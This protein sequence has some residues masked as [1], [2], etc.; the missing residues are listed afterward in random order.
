MPAVN[1]VDN[2]VN[3]TFDGLNG[4]IRTIN[5]SSIIEQFKVVSDGLAAMTGPVI[6]FEQSMADLSSITGTVGRDLA[7][8]GRVARQTGRESGLGAEQAPR[9]FME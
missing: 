2:S 6:G 3:Q 8:L 5:F 9:T 4:K 1:Q 7:E